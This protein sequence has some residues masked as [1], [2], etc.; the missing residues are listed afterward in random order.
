MTA[1]VYLGNSPHIVKCVRPVDEN[2]NE[3]EPLQRYVHIGMFVDTVLFGE[4]VNFYIYTNSI[5]FYCTAPGEY[6]IIN[7]SARTITVIVEDDYRD[8]QPGERITVSIRTWK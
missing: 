8:I 5:K 7:N 1:K 3:G 4:L 2:G 6:E